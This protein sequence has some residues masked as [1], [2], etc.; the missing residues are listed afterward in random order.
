MRIK[1]ISI[2]AAAAV[3]FLCCFPS[4]SALEA[5]GCDSRSSYDSA[6][7]YWK[8]IAVCD[9]YREKHSETGETAEAVRCVC[10]VGFSQEDYTAYCYHIEVCGKYERA[11]RGEDGVRECACGKIFGNDDYPAFCVHAA[12]CE[13]AQD[14]SNINLCGF[15]KSEFSTPNALIEHLNSFHPGI[16]TD[17]SEGLVCPYCSGRFRDENA[18]NDH[19]V[20]CYSQRATL[21]DSDGN[22]SSWGTY[23]KLIGMNASELLDRFIDLARIDAAKWGPIETA[24]IRLIDFTENMALTVREKDE[25][26]VLGAVDRLEEKICALDLDSSEFEGSMNLLGALREKISAAYGEEKET[27]TGPPPAAGTTER[28]ETADTGSRNV[29][30][31]VFTAAAAACAVSFICLRKKEKNGG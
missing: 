10:G 1:R 11:V 21:T 23:D 24:V 16:G 26:E 14:R 12:G 13:A 3:T 6:D 29:S 27:G 8:H 17:A 19:I 25:D 7:G 22:F 18:Y 15:C 9:E 5:G 30:A 28:T 4:A 2:L 20:I 31:A